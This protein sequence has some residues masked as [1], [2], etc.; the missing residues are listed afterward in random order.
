MMLDIINSI[1]CMFME[2][3]NLDYV[4]STFVERHQH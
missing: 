4:R 2:A 3:H 1:V